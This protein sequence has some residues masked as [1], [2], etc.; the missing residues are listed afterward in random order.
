MSGIMTKVASYGFIRVVFDLLGA[1]AWWSGVAVLLL[2]GV[3]AVMGILYGAMV[4]N[5]LPVLWY[6]W[7]LPTAL[8]PTTPAVPELLR[9]CLAVMAAGVFVSGVR[10]LRA[11]LVGHTSQVLAVAFSPAGNQVATG[12]VDGTSRVWRL[13]GGLADVERPERASIDAVA[14]VSTSWIR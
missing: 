5:L 10:D 6:W 4:A 12:S 7:S 8:A 13:D 9:W 14:L 11:S 1:P 3:T 2:G